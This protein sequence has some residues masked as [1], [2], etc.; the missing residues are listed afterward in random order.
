MEE[1]PLI[2]II[3]PTHGKNQYLKSAIQSVKAQ[4]YRNI[5]LIIIDDAS[6]APEI[7]EDCIGG[8]SEIRVKHIRFD[9]TQGGAKARNVGISLA[10]GLPPFKFWC[11]I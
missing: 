3:I 9:H 4:T 6:A 2:S 5:E 7:V 10:E 8:L 1:R 11:L